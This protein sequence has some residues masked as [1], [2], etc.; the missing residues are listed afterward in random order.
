[1][2]QPLEP[3]YVRAE[4]FRAVKSLPLV[5]RVEIALGGEPAKAAG[6]VKYKTS[7]VQ[8]RTVGEIRHAAWR[9]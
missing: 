9:V 1:M 4:A 2:K 6:E 8:I 3:T 7:A 5:G